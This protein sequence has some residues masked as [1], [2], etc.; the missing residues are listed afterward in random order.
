VL[1]QLREQKLLTFRDGFVTFLDYA[2]LTAFADFDP[3]YL[4]QVGPLLKSR[5]DS[6]KSAQAASG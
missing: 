5:G 6:V 4:D 2:R 1:R 3:T